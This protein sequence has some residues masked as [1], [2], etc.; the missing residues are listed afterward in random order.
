M[1]FTLDIDAARDLLQEEDS[2][3]LDREGDNSITVLG[4][5]EITRY[6]DEI[7]PDEAHQLVRYLELYA[8]AKNNTQ[9]QYVVEPIIN[10]EVKPGVW[11]QVR[12]YV[13]MRGEVATV[14]QVLRKGWRTTLLNGGNLDFSEAR[15]IKMRELE[16]NDQSVADVDETTSD[17]EEKYLMVRFP[18]LAVTH[19]RAI[20][21]Q[22]RDVVLVE[23]FTIRGETFTEEYRKVYASADI[24][25][26]DGSM[27]V[28]VLFAQ[29]QFT[30]NSYTTWGKAAGLF[31]G[32]VSYLWGVPKELTQTIVDDYK[33]LGPGRSASVSYNVSQGLVD[34]VLQSKRADGTGDLTKAPWDS[35][36]VDGG[37]RTFY[38]C[39]E[40]RVTHYFW[41]V[42]NPDAGWYEI[43]LEL[44]DPLPVG[45]DGP[46]TPEAVPFPPATGVVYQ[47]SV[48]S[49]G[50]DTYDVVIEV[51]SEQTREA[52]I[53]ELVVQA[54]YF[55]VTK[56]TIDRGLLE[57]PVD[58]AQPDG[59]TETRVQSQSVELKGNCA[60]DRNA[61]QRIPTSRQWSW[62]FETDHGD[63]TVYIGRNCT[64]A[65]Y[66]AILVT[67]DLQQVDSNNVVK[68]Y[69][70]HGLID[71]D[72][73]KREGPGGGDAWVGGSKVVD[74]EVTD[75]NGVVWH[76]YRKWVN[77]ASAAK[78]YITTSAGGTIRD[79]G[80]SHITTVSPA[81]RGRLVA[82][83]VEY[84]S[85]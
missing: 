33:A 8:S 73:T 55:G 30:I 53:D 57:T 34:I 69:N 28:D 58:L 47:K 7:Q 27:F 85:G 19:S 67:A 64:A 14:V 80:G 44:P 52:A 36:D 39:S 49:N 51:S 66:A 68:K 4:D 50:D 1:S 56:R 72:I 65:Q 45:W 60:I 10:G 78:T 48:S 46:T 62:T 74:W 5:A 11:R 61:D 76:I 16:G 35:G 26:S 71:Y 12:V 29:S 24:E 22:L 20:M 40:I 13:D 37:L 84:I 6:W 81:S 17:D 2:R 42:E 9:Q 82:T 59:S 63:T 23:N 41:D 15:I 77:T 25:Q 32:L 43:G 38:S 70:E 31:G 83:R 3:R 75:K 54:D 79:R 18:N 21:A